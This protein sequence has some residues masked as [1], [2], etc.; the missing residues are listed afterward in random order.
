MKSLFALALVAG[1]AAPPRAA[2]SAAVSGADPVALAGEHYHVL[3]EN[4]R[5]RVLDFKLGP[6]EKVP[7][8][9]H[10]DYVMHALTPFKVR[11]TGAD[12]RAKDFEGPAGL[13]IYSDALVHADENLGDSEFHVL[14]FELKR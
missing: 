14:I 6:G 1:L 12:G 3:L 5:V 10:P 9:A 11:F 8:H 7:L 4:D 13:T 2:A